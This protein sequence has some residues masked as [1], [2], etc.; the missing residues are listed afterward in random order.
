MYIGTLYTLRDIY[1]PDRLSLVA[2]NIRELME[3]IPQ[4][5]D[6]TIPVH[7]SLKDMVINIRE[8]WENTKKDMEKLIPIFLQQLEDFF[9][10]FEKDNPSRREDVQKFLHQCD[11]MLDTLPDTLEKELIDEW[12]DIREYFL[13]VSHHRQKQPEEEVFLTNLDRLE[14]YLLSRFYSKTSADFDAI[15]DVIREAEE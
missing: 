15:D 10:L 2:H 3:K 13:A 11:P 5:M 4:Y 1:N 7:R 9:I 6:V 12:Q 14:N 8:H